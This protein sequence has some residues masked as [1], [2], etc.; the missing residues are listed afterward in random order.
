MTIQLIIVRCK[1]EYAE[2]LH[3]SKMRKLNGGNTGKTIIHR[4][5]K[6]IEHSDET[7]LSNL[8]CQM[9]RKANTENVQMEF[10][11]LAVLHY[12][13]LKYIEIGSLISET[14]IPENEDPKICA[15]IRTALPVFVS[16]VEWATLRDNQH[17]IS[18]GFSGI[19]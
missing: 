13:Y 1:L 15:W 7:F 5:F 11:P 4:N 3:L 2:W 16:H 10:T 8:I 9:S 19:I 17:N 18:L 14:I 12:L 6:A